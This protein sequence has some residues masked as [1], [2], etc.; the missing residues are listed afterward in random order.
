MAFQNTKRKRIDLE[1]S[2]NVI[3]HWITTSIVRSQQG[4]QT[5]VI[6]HAGY[7]VLSYDG[8]LV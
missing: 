7:R 4:W 3:L 5:I 8:F 2:T 1:N 6:V